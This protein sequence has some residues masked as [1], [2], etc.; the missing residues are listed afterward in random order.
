MRFLASVYLW[1]W[2]LHLWRGFPNVSFTSDPGP[3]LSFHAEVKVASLLR[4]E[5]FPSVVFGMPDG[6]FGRP[7]CR[8]TYLMLEAFAN[9]E[10]ATAPAGALARFFQKE[11]CTGNVGKPPPTHLQPQFG[12]PAPR[13]ETTADSFPFIVTTSL[14]CCMLL[15]K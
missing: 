12:A 13:G 3:T 7:C 4:E 6:A 5:S 9:G 8:Q 1:D 10:P 14:T 2:R 15:F 11:I